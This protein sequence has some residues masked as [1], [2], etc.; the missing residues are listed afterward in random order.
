M[1]DAPLND[2]D[3]PPREASVGI[4]VID[5]LETDFGDG[6][7]GIWQLARGAELTV[8]AVDTRLL[9]EAPS[10]HRSTSRLWLQPTLRREPRFGQVAPLERRC[11]VC[12]WER[13]SHCAIRSLS[14]IWRRALRISQTD[15]GAANERR[16]SL[17]FP[18]DRWSS[19]PTRCGSQRSN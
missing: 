5:S 6:M 18:A 9:L 10:L 2:G 3:A 17:A 7:K 4:T 13:G 8:L 16:R 19:F 11:E 1:C 14:P 15:M 12:S